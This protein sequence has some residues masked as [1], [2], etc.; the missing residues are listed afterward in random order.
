[1]NVQQPSEKGPALPGT[2]GATRWLMRMGN[3][4]T[5]ETS[6]IYTRE[7]VEKWECSVPVQPIP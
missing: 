1:M 3:G 2:P 6:G 4:Q 7:Q 5:F